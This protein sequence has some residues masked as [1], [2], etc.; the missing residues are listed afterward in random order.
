[1][2][3][4]KC[5]A[6]F[7]SLISIA[8]PAFAWG[9]EGHQVV[10]DIA[11]S[12]LTAAAKLEVRELLGN[13]DLAAVSTWPDEIKSE[14]PETFGWHFVDIPRNSSGFSEERDC[15]RPEEKHP[16]SLQ[17]HHNCVVDRISIFEQVLANKNAPRGDRIEALEFLVHFVGDVHQPLHAIAD[18]RGGN[19][20]RVSEFGSTQC[21]K[22][23][24]N[25]HFAWDIGLIEHASRREKD[26]AAYLEKVIL[27][28]NLARKADGTPEEWA[29]ESFRLAKQ[30]WLNDG[31]SVDETYYR[32]NI[33]IVDEHLALAG[34]R[35]AK[36][37]NRV[38]AK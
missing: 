30:V 24:C 26:Y 25:L 27:R 8:V 32:A 15:Y 3:L 20:I 9:P 35:L 22:F 31:S 10:G 34:L 6:F 18:A 4:T 17:D 29:N 37:L 33:H 12:H 28:E 19:D 7:I 2:L 13:D 23:P 38:F 36:I 5:T 16:S 11:R 21:G 1:M 14:R